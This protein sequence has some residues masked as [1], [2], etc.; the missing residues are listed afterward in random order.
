[1]TI[2]LCCPLIS[3]KTVPPSSPSSR[4]GRPASPERNWRYHPGTLRSWRASMGQLLSAVFAVATCAL[5]SGAAAQEDG[6]PVPIEKASYH[7][8]AFTNEYVTVLN[9]YVPPQRS[10]GY[11]THSRD[12]VS[13]NVEQAT[14]MN[15]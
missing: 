15:Q 7:L 12:S 1:M 14:T 3:C 4:S 8:P 9:I 6:P 13:V 2:Y 11:H 5:V 10:T